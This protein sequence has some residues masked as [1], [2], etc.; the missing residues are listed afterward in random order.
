MA[1]Y[2]PLRYPGGKGKLIDYIIQ[3]MKCNNLLGG[4]YVEPYAGGA[5][6]ALGLLF[7]EYVTNIVINDIDS[8]IYAFWVSVLDHTDELCQMIEKTAVTVEEWKRQKHIQSEKQNYSNLEI[9]FSTFFLNRTNRSGIIKGGVIGGFEQSGAWKIDARFNKKDLI[10]RI[11]RIA[12]YRENIRV[13]NLDSEKLIEENIST[14]ESRTLVY[15]DPPYYKKGNQLYVN[16]Y[17][18]SDHLKLSEVIKKIKQ[19][20]IVTYDNVQQVSSLYSDYK[21]LTYSLS[22]SASNRCMGSEIMIFSDK[23]FAPDDISSGGLIFA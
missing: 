7:N 23:T 3:I 18:P 4:T 22:Y 14:F 12:K 8:A 11:E 15:L 10:T 1:Y 6:V 19:H 9:G 13:Y 21:Q 20:W 17:K 5:A 2:S 16:F